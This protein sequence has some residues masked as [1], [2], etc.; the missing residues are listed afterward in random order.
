MS[1]LACKNCAFA[2]LSF[3]SFFKRS[4]SWCF[5]CF[6]CWILSA[7]S[8]MAFSRSAC[9]ACSCSSFC[10]LS[11]ACFCCCSSLARSRILAKVSAFSVS[12]CCFSS[13]F[14]N[15]LSRFSSSSFA[16]LACEISSRSRNSA[17][18]ISSSNPWQ[19]CSA[20][21]NALKRSTGAFSSARICRMM[22][23]RFSISCSSSRRLRSNSASLS[24]R[25]CSAISARTFSTSSSA[26]RTFSLSSC[27]C[28]TSSCLLRSSICSAWSRLSNCSCNSSL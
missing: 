21:S 17:R 10:R 12:S 22:S 13:F 1:A 16:S 4:S 9:W 28:F 24:L 26:A 25:T 3:S 11:A 18:D 5:R 15:C 19:G 6:L 20:G 14:S 7:T 27:V 8:R 2:A 23:F